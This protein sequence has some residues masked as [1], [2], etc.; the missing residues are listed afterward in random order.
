MYHGC[1]R[2]LHPPWWYCGL[3]FVAMLWLA[4]RKE[5]SLQPTDGV[6][7]H[8]GEVSIDLR[9]IAE[10]SSIKAVLKFLHHHCDDVVEHQFLNPILL[11]DG[12]RHSIRGVI[13]PSMRLLTFFPCDNWNWA[14]VAELPFVFLQDANLVLGP[15]YNDTVIAHLRWGGWFVSLWIHAT[16]T[17][18]FNKEAVA[19]SCGG[20]IVDALVIVEVWRFITSF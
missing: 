1:R 18:K 14:V 10:I 4:K 3:F 15:C 17:F 13:D 2:H 7:Y 9:W 19:W 5:A 11:V 8:N 16:A 20:I 12:W 6:G